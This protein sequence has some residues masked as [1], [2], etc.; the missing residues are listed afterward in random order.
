[1]SLF[2]AIN[3]SGTGVDAMQT[4][5][6]AD[7]GNIANANDAVSPGQTPYQEQEAVFSPTADSA[8]ADGQPGVSVA[9]DTVSSPGELETDADDPSLGKNGEIVLPAI[10]LSDQLTG[11]M[12]AQDGYQADTSAISRALSAYQ[13]GMQIGS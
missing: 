3:T 13:A 2:G 6:D 10:S 9:V 5:I 1:M 7:A 8:V 4:W 12:Q 11:L